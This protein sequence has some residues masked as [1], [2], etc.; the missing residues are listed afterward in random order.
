MSD[1]A[2]DRAGQPLRTA[3]IGASPEGGWARES[4][5]PAVQGLDGYELTAVLARS[6]RSADAARDAFGARR[7]Y[8]DPA[9]LF[10]DE[11]IDVVT[12][13]VRVPAHRDLLLGA[14]RAGKHVVCEWPLG[15]DL[16]EARDL[17][18]AAA[19]AGGHAV[20]GLQAR[21]SPAVTRARELVAGGVIGRVLS[22]R[23]YD[24]TIAFGPGITPGDAY[25]E[26]PANGATHIAIHGGHA[27]DLGAFLLGG[28]TPASAL[29]SVQYPRV[30]VEGGEPLTRVVPDHL[31]VLARTGDD[32]PAVVE[33]VGGRPERDTSFRAQ[34]TGTGH[35]LTL[36]GHAARGF[37][38]GRL[39]LF[40]DAERQDI[41][42]SPQLPDAA[43][44]VAGLYRALR[45]DIAAGTSTAPGLDDAVAL[46]E[47]V[48][49][50]K[51]G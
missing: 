30:D 31:L 8:A 4:H 24:S 47:L 46:T 36:T 5:V 33:V 11:Q 51:A 2:Q 17:R 42:D 10:A 14:V 35:E 12:V 20:I 44:N 18:A 15:R 22:A 40:L 16:A 34:I 1:H 25:L 26:A 45:A 43:A 19:R 32:A 28:L 23:I 37:Q 6:Q 41:P 29:T 48:A 9:E 50:A 38:S 3:I 39:T 7:G 21:M 13:A 49:F 27:L